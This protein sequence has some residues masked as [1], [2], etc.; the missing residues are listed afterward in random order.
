LRAQRL[1]RIR[2]QRAALI[3]AAD[4]LAQFAAAIEQTGTED[5]KE[6]DQ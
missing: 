1:E 3:A 6:D 2:W 4:D 5:R